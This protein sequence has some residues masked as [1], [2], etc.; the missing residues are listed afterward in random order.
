MARHSSVA[1]VKLAVAGRE[2]VALVQA[3]EGKIAAGRAGCWPMLESAAAR[4]PLE[5][6]LDQS[7]RLEASLPSAVE[8]EAE[9]EPEAEVAV[10]V[11]VAAVAVAV[12]VVGLEVDQHYFFWTSYQNLA[13]E[14]TNVW[15]LLKSQP[16]RWWPFHQL[17]TGEC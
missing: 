17:R 10:E 2:L 16:A 7:W 8:A 9:A 13:A 6:C 1:V 3:A 14:P 15:A 12:A 4:P 5:S 11:V